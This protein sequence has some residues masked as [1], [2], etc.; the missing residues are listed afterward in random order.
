M[1]RLPLSWKPPPTVPPASPRWLQCAAPHLEKAGVEFTN[2][3]RP[4]VRLRAGSELPTLLPFFP[5]AGDPSTCLAVWAA[6]AIHS[7]VPLLQR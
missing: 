7:I 1:A 6:A 2:G 3:K 4:K 5:E